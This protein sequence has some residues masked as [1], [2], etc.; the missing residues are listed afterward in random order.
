MRTRLS[1]GCHLISYGEMLISR[2]YPYPPKALL[3]RRLNPVYLSCPITPWISMIFPLGWVSPGKNISFKKADALY[4]YAIS[5]PFGYRR[6]LDPPPLRIFFVLCRHVW[7]FSGTTQSWRLQVN[8]VLSQYYEGF[9]L[10]IIFSKRWWLWDCEQ[11]VFFCL[12]FSSVVK[13]FWVFLLV[14]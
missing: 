12:I 3:F 5:F 11:T 6:L 13:I 14:V 7:M 1:K 8:R 9:A 10:V 2:K 4:F